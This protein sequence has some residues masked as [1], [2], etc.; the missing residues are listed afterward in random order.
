MEKI[1]A[2]EVQVL[3][4]KAEK[5]RKLHAQILELIAFARTNPKT[6]SEARQLEIVVRK[7][8]GEVL[9]M[10]EIFAEKQDQKN[11]V[12][13]LSKPAQLFIYEDKNGLSKAKD[14]M[15]HHL[16]LC[17]AIERKIFDDD[18]QMVYLEDGKIDNYPKFSAEGEV[19]IVEK[20]LEKCAKAEERITNELMFLNEYTRDHRLCDKAEVA[21]MEFLF[22]KRDY[23]EVVRD[24]ERFV[25][26]Y[27]IRY[28]GVC[29]PAQLR[30][31]QSENHDLIMYYITRSEQII[32]D[33]E[34]I[35][36]LI[37]RGNKE[38]VTAYFERYEQED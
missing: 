5:E 3:R 27:I 22:I 25:L 13:V 15:L 4:T 23:D 30:L 20:T 18:L 6:L 11:P 35:D 14:Y 21:L 31:I 37:E 32:D 9:K 16:S 38:E 28:H 33:K 2:E 12:C 17:T 29:Q 10:L 8:E 26:D 34:V 24:L 7:R 36:A 1:T 19:Y